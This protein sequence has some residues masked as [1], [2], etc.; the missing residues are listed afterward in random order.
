MSNAR[1][2]GS[3]EALME[4][5]HCAIQ[6]KG[7]LFVD[8]SDDNPKD[9]KTDRKKSLMQVD[10][11]AALHRLTSNLAFP[12][13]V[14]KQ[15]LQLLLQR[16]CE[17][18]EW[19]VAECDQAEY[20][21]CMLRRLVNLCRHI[22][23]AQVKRA[24]WSK[25]LPW[26]AVGGHTRSAAGS[27]RRRIRDKTP[28]DEEEG[29]QED[30]KEEDD[31]QPPKK[32][33]SSSKGRL[34]QGRE[35]QVQPTQDEAEPQKRFIH[36]YDIELRQ[37]WR[38]P[39]GRATAKLKEFA[40]T[41]GPAPGAKPKDLILPRWADGDVWSVTDLTV[42]RWTAMP[43]SR[44]NS[45]SSEGSWTSAHEVSHNEVCVKL[46]HDSCD[47]IVIREQCRQVLQTETNRFE[48]KSDAMRL[49][50]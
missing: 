10:V 26:L 34:S 12:R 49:M 3:E 27:G 20:L 25:E 39:I 44:E 14:M 2:E 8:Y 40:D 38:V 28:K 24:D 32:R 7:R 11:L 18:K 48:T 15:A 41:T 43:T 19:K 46:R 29:A 50:V 37:A 9:A 13:S 31:T 4:A 16:N 30:V 23:Q 42:E 36:G 45:A 47:L 17:A 22:A 5:I 33:K 1:F 35:K 6:H 21:E